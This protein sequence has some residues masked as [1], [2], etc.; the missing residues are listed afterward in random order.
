MILFPANTNQEL[1][2]FMRKVFDLILVFLLLA[3]LF[4]QKDK[5]LNDYHYLQTG[6]CDTPITY[7]LGEVDPGY[8][9]T[10][11]QFLVKVQEAEQIWSRIVLIL[12]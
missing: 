4:W 7:R 8:G 9:L 1:I 10:S 3:F 12:S 2:K 6:P 5:I 11:P